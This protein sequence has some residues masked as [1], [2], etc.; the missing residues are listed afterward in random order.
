MHRCALGTAPRRRRTTRPE[1]DTLRW[2]RFLPSS[3]SSRALGFTGIEAGAANIA[4]LLFHVFVALVVIFPVPGFTILK[5]RRAGTPLAVTRQ[6]SLFPNSKGHPV[7]D[8]PYSEDIRDLFDW[9]SAVARV[10]QPGG[11]AS[12]GVENDDLALALQLLTCNSR[13]REQFVGLRG[14]AESAA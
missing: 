5:R 4:R 6:I 13:D 10:D 8:D 2:P 12:A 14:G 3:Q 9:R 7:I 11:A 1:Q